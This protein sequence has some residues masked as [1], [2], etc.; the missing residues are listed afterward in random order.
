M[1]LVF[2]LKYHPDHNQQ[3]QHHQDY[4]AALFQN[5]GWIA[6][7]FQTYIAEFPFAD[8]PGNKAVSPGDHHDSQILFDASAIP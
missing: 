4:I 7:I 8:S 2:R 5:K 3:H 6:S 1:L